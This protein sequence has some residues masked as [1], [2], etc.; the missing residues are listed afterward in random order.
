MAETIQGGISYSDY[1]QQN[2][3]LAQEPS[4][5]QAK[6]AL[7]FFNKRMS[8]QPGFN[9]EPPEVKEQAYQQFR[10]KYNVPDIKPARGALPQAPQPTAVADPGVNPIEGLK[11]IANTFGQGLAGFGQAAFNPQTYQQLGQDAGKAIQTELQTRSTPPQGLQGF[12]EKAV[13]GTPTGLLPGA[14]QGARDLVQGGLSLPADLA[15]AYQGQNVYEP[16]ARLP[17]VLP[18]LRK[19][20]PV[21]SFIGEQVPYSIPLTRAAQATRAP[22]F[23]RALAEG[24]G[25]GAV[26]DPRESGLQGRVTNAAFGSAIPTALGVAGRALNRIKVSPKERPIGVSRIREKQN[27]QEAQ[28]KQQN[29]RESATEGSEKQQPQ[30][31]PTGEQREKAVV[32]QKPVGGTI[33]SR[34]GAASD[35]LQKTESKKQEGRRPEQAQD[36]EDRTGL[37]R[38]GRDQGREPELQGAITQEAKTLQEKVQDFRGSKLDSERMALAT[39]IYSMAQ[40]VDRGVFREALKDLPQEVINDLGKR[41]GC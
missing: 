22:Q 38:E 23:G 9:E 29:R 11:N 40:E 35:L 28:T 24:T 39:E 31:T 25:I 2:P 18:E 34:E 1:L 27:V 37:G 36:L 5:I 41:V 21:T 4:E 6:V 19:R 14:L 10:A 16:A 3:T 33:P 15:N 13:M 30:T 8:A 26:I 12:I 32:Q 17:E 20:Y 7:E